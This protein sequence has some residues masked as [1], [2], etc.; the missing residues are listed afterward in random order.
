LPEQQAQR[1]I[2]DFMSF[3]NDLDATRSQSFSASC[4]ELFRALVDYYGPWDSSRRYAIG[5]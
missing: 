1:L 3:T 4:P 2:R 5:G